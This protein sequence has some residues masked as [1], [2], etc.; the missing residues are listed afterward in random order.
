MNKTIIFRADGNN[1]IGLGHL[2][3]LFALAEMY[4]NNYKFIFLTREDTSF[5]IFPINYV[6]DIIPKSINIEFEPNWINLNF[7]SNKYIVIA[8][9]YQFKSLYQKKLKEYG[10]Y[11]IYI[12]DLASEHMFADLV[13]NHTPKIKKNDYNS[14]KHT[15]FLL[16]TD[17]AMLRP[18]FVEAAKHL[19]SIEHIKTV[20]VCFGGADFHD[21]TF[22]STQAFLK[23]HSFK[24]VSVILGAA[25]KHKE[26]FKLKTDFPNIDIYRNLNESEMLSLIRSSDI[27]IAPSSTISYEIIAVG[28]HLISGYFI[29][30]QQKI[31][32]GLV[33]KNVIYGMGNFKNASVEDF[34]K[35]IKSTVNNLSNTIIE[36]QRTLIDGKQKNRFLDIMKSI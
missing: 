16:G 13:I 34:Y 19:K 27:G 23:M 30:N 24:K 5:D 14:E 8:D 3:R 9:G 36:N 1:K 11:L 18:L 4:K 25:Y 15:N 29:S 6:I 35:K 32:D 12:D 33:K 26:I 2:Y 28:M 20:F 22:K 17:Y 10:F 7:S 31:Y 21:L